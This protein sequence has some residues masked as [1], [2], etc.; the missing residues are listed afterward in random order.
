[1]P[2]GNTPEEFGAFLK[3]EMARWGKIIKQ[4]GIRSEW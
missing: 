2:V 1:L 3:A 4:K